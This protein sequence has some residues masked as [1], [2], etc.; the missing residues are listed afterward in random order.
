MGAR[1]T[2]EEGMGGA[3]EEGEGGGMEEGIGVVAEEGL[4]G[5]EEEG[6]VEVGGAVDGAGQLAEWA[7]RKEI[8]EGKW[9][10]TGAQSKL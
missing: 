9:G 8:Q 10:G 6:G 3:E 2:E 4:G 1:G 5:A 7:R